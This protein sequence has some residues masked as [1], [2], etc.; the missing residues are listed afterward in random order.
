MWFDSLFW[1]GSLCLRMVLGLDRTSVGMVAYV[2]TA[3]SLKVSSA[4]E[5]I[6]KD[7]EKL[8]WPKRSVPGSTNPAG[9]KQED[10][11]LA[12]TP[13]CASKPEKAA[14]KCPGWQQYRYPGSYPSLLHGI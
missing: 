7:N 2:T 5:S 12:S 3:W 9:E 1:L 13:T 10:G 6:R 4:L 11:P 14:M 8:S